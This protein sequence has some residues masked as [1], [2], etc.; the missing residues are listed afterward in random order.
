MKITNLDISRI[1][2]IYFIKETEKI[3]KNII[4]S[5]ETLSTI[6]SNHL[7]GSGITIEKV[8]IN[9]NFVT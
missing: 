4:K 8:D 1:W 2:Q 5:K 7:N 9:I 3:I 6:E